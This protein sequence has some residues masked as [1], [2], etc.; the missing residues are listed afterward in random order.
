MANLS[1][2]SLPDKASEVLV[3]VLKYSSQWS[4]S[5]Y[6]E[7]FQVLK[8]YKAGNGPHFNHISRSKNNVF[9]SGL[10][11]HVNASRLHSNFFNHYSSFNLRCSLK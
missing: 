1:L 6:V 10:Q 9:F 3:V 2:A 8:Y 4:F 11:L 5:R 7:I